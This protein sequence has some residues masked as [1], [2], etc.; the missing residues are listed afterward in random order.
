MQAIQLNLFPPA[1]PDGIV[2][3]AQET[4][5]MLKCSTYIILYGDVWY[6]SNRNDYPAPWEI[7]KE[8]KPTE[9]EAN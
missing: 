5:D 6:I 4:A 9:N 1:L 3:S 8:V 2:E 7:I